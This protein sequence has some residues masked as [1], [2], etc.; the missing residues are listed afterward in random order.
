MIKIKGDFRKYYDAIFP[1]FNYLMDELSYVEDEIKNKEEISLKFYDNVDKEY[2]RVFET[3]EKNK[4][5]VEHLFFN[6]GIFNYCGKNL[7]K[8]ID[9]LG[10]KTNLTSQKTIEEIDRTF[11][12]LKLYNERIAFQYGVKNRRD[13]VYLFTI[14]DSFIQEII[15]DTLKYILNKSEED[16]FAKTKIIGRNSLK[17]KIDWF[18]QFGYKPDYDVVSIK[19]FTIRR[20]AIVHNCSRYSQSLLDLLSCEDAKIYNL[21]VNQNVQLPNKE[22]LELIE[23]IKMWSNNLIGYLRTRFVYDEHTSKLINIDLHDELRL[24]KMSDWKSK[25]V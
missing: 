7:E 1:K 3:I 2:L 12:A 14:F 21:K 24:I 23:N 6:S 25:N 8:V 20:H 11:F 9:I 16:I 15:K 10:I 18:K 4:H 19:Y 13:L 5:K 22:I 17:Q